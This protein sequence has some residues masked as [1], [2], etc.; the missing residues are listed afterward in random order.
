LTSLSFDALLRDVFLPLSSGATL[1]LPD[2]DSDLSADQVLRWL[3]RERVTLVHTVPAMAQTW[4]A[5]PPA[6]ISL[7]ALRY[8]F[9]SGEPLSEALVRRWR[10]TFPEAGEIVNLYGPTETTMTKFFFRVGSDA[11]ISPGVQPVGW[12]LPQTQALVISKVGQVCGMGE[13]GEI[14][15]RTPFRTLGYIGAGREAGER[16]F[17]RNPFGE[18]EG[19]L[20]Y[21]TGDR[22]RYRSDGA[23]EY[24]GRLDQQVK[25]RGVRVEP[26]EIEAVLGEHPAVR[27]SV[28]VAQEEDAPSGAPIESKRLVGYVVFG[29]EELVD[30]IRELRGYLRE[31]LPEY[32]VP[33]AFVLLDKLPLTPNGKVDH[34]ALPAPERSAVSLDDAY[35]APR[36]PVEEAL[37]EIWTEVLRVEQ[38][39]AHSD[40]FELGGHSL[41]ATLVI[42]RV[43]EVFQVQLPLRSLFEEPT[44]AGLAERVEVAQQSNSVPSKATPGSDDHEEVLL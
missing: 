33:S 6:G 43:R 30:P 26:G 18:E 24:L 41:L 1:C 40:F 4:L 14:V 17:V 8:V 38:V 9:F 5:Y 29:G 42:S 7:G 10:E 23:L 32:M 21:Y 34:K 20:L 11:E 36:T 39:G 35:V 12:P 37:A 3:E 44:V 16:R 15:I 31:R 25:I 13:P 19:D 27:E 28:V 22:G 2:A